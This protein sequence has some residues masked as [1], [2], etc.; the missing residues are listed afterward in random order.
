MSLGQVRQHQIERM[1]H[2]DARITIVCRDAAQRQQKRNNGRDPVERSQPAV[3]FQIM[4][5]Q[6]ASSSRQVET[7]KLEYCTNMESPE[8]RR[9]HPSEFLGT[10]NTLHSRFRS[11]ALLRS[12]FSR[13]GLLFLHQTASINNAFSLQPKPDNTLAAVQ[14]Q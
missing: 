7:S 4:Q 13:L 1:I 14:N 6:T 2:H 12:S 5:S 9:D 3:Y 10:R 8:F 11:S